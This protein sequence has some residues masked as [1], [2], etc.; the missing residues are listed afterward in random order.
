MKKVFVI[1]FAVFIIASVFAGGG[2]QTSSV[3]EPEVTVRLLTDATGVDDKSFNAAAW[4]GILQFYG[5]TWET[6]AQRGTAYD[7]ITAQTQDMYIP[8]L[9]LTTDEAPDL[10]IT[11]GFTFADALMEVA[12]KNPEQKYMI[13]DVDW[14]VAPNVMQFMFSEHEGSYLVGVAAALKAKADGIANPQFGFIGGVPG[15]TITKFEVGYIQGVLS[16]FP[17]A[18]FVDYYTNDW[19]KPELAKTQAKNWYD[20]GVYAVYS[21]AGSSGNG[22]I[23][24]AKEYRAQGQKVWAIGV[25]S[26]QHEEGIYSDSEPSAVLTSM[27]KMVETGAIMGLE[28]VKNNTFKG[29]TVILDLESD[30]VGYSQRNDALTPDIITQIEAAKAKI[31][32]GEI[33]VA[34]TYAKAKA[35]PGFPQNLKAIDD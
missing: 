28:A 29:E 31:I 32:S 23:A 2:Q 4:R 8:N 3:A 30:G 17:N 22:T 33:T 26:D 35:L 34:D 14:V 19:G 24:Q 9:M 18:Q 25:D 20:A 16:V 10:I 12:A 11:T 5:D 6:Q 1:F 13:V 21:A 15:L 7:V 27:L